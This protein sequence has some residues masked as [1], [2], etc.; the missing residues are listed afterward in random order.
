[1]KKVLGNKFCFSLAFYTL[2]E[3]KQKIT[4]NLTHKRTVYGAFGGI[5]KTKITNYT[6]ATITKTPDGYSI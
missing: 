6:L 3:E 4:K 5:D 1:M 2:T